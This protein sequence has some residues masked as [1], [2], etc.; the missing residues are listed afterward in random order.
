MSKVTPFRKAPSFQ[1]RTVSQAEVIDIQELLKKTLAACPACE[2]I[3]YFTHKHPVFGTIATS[4]CPCGGTDEDR[5][6]LNDFG[7]AA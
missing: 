1:C 2:G 6:D 7:G 5:I 4:P 3:G